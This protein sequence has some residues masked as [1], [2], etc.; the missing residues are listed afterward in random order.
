MQVSQFKAQN[1]DLLVKQ[2][3]AA[4]DLHDA[5]LVLAFGAPA[6]LKAPGLYAALRQILPQAILAGCSTAGEISSAGI[7]D[8]SLVITAVRFDQVKVSVA[9]TELAGMEDSLAAGA[10]LGQQLKAGSPKAVLLFGQGLGIN[11]SALIDGMRGS[12]GAAVPI[13]GGLAGDGPHFRETV[14]L[15]PQ[16]ASSS[17]LVAVGLHG[18]ALCFSHGSFGGWSPFGTLRKVSRSSGN[19]LFELDD[20]PALEIY[21]NFLGDY[22]RDLPSSG[23]LF[24]FEMIDKTRS[25]TGVIRTILAV[26]EADG[27]LTLAGDIDPEGYLRLMH[28]STDQLV[29]GAEAAANAAKNMAGH[30][31]GGLGILVSCV[32]RKLAMGERVDEEIEAVADIFGQNTALAGFYSYG[33]ISPFAPGAP[34]RLH[35]QTMTVTWIAEAV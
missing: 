22:A 25:S 10:R 12:V 18:E 9:F 6:L 26:G 21:K 29:N 24:P 15:T 19:V 8:D 7:A 31:A 5:Q 14:V 20:R 27:S 35:N 3:T 16:G 2:M 13:T 33:E 30:P 32:G 34:C 23:L 28:A 11:G 4:S 17:A 1:V